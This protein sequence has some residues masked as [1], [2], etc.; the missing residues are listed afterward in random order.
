[1]VLEPTPPSGPDAGAIVSTLAA[2]LAD[3]PELRELVTLFVR[4]LGRRAETLEQGLGSDDLATLRREA[5]RLIG[6]ARS[7]GFPDLGAAASELER[8]A[9]AGGPKEALREWTGRLVDLCRR[10]VIRP[11]TPSRVATD[12]KKSGR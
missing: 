11:E 8:H 5:N 7:F 12:G 4:G 10:T 1:M 2:Q 6:P 3:D 9:R